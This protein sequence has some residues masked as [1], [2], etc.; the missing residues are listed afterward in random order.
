MAKIYN[1]KLSKD[2]RGQLLVYEE[3]TEVEFSDNNEFVTKDDESDGRNVLL[4]YNSKLLSFSAILARLHY[5]QLMK[6]ES[7]MLTNLQHRSLTGVNMK[8]TYPINLHP[9]QPS[10]Q[11]E[12]AAQL[13]LNDLRNRLEEIRDCELRTFFSVRDE[14]ENDLDSISDD[15]F[16][17]VNNYLPNSKL[18]EIADRQ[19]GCEVDFD[20]RNY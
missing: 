20:L 9:D 11:R 3:E 4:E 8:L 19:T 1:Y 18:F 12:P 15:I 6:K 16:E 14:L 10:Q 7:Y 5:T 2:L 13:F 17:V